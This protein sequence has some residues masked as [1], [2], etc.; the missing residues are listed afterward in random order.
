MTCARV[1]VPTTMPPA[2]VRSSRRKST[3]CPGRISVPSRS[4]GRYPAVTGRC[5]AA[6]RPAAA[7]ALPA[8]AR[9]AS[10]RSLRSP[11]GRLALYTRTASAL[12]APACWSRMTRARPAAARPRYSCPVP[13]S[14]AA[15]ARQARAA[16]CSRGQG[17]GEPVSGLGVGR[18]PRAPA[19][20]VV[21][22]APRHRRRLVPRPGKEAA[23]GLRGTAGRDLRTRHR[24]KQRGLPL[25]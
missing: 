24:Y 8:A 13:K 16:V 3:A 15:A 7:R 14:M 25:P 9:A 18:E 23:R 2:T 19:R 10:T 20:L 11:S 22:L 1:T 17:R 12:A 4:R 5:R 21:L 6:A